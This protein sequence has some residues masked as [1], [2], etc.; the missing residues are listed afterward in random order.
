[1]HLVYVVYVFSLG[2]NSQEQLLCFH[3][4]K[5]VCVNIPVFV[6][7]HSFTNSVQLVEARGPGQQMRMSAVQ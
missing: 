4:D 7:G 1:M 6:D 3:L 5:R 2:L